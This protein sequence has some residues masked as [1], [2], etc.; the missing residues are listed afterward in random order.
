MSRGNFFSVNIIYQNTRGINSKLSLIKCFPDMSLYD[1]ICITE[2]WLKPDTPSN[3]IFDSE[4]FKVFRHDRLG[5]KGG[6][7]LVAVNFS[8]KISVIDMSPYDL[9]NYNI[10]IIALNIS[11]YTITF[12][13]LLIYIPPNTPADSYR[14]FFSTLMN[15]QALYDNP[16]IVIG[17]FNSP[18]FVENN[19]NLDFRTRIIK[20]FALAF[21]LMQF[22]NVKD[23]NGKCLDLA[24]ANFECSLERAP[25][26]LVPEDSYHPTL[27]IS[28]FLQMSHKFQP[29]NFITNTIEQN[30]QFNF[31]KA[32]LSDLYVYLSLIDWTILYNCT[33]VN[34]AYDIFITILLECFKLFVPVYSFSQNKIRKYPPWF[35]KSVIREI[36]KKNYLLKKKRRYKVNIYDSE[37]KLMS[38]FIHRSIKSEHDN[39]IANVERNI[40][41]NPKFFWS[42]VNRSRRD[43]SFPDVMHY[44]NAVL[45]EPQAIV[46]AFSAFFAKHCT[47]TSNISNFNALTSSIDMG[48][49]LFT[50]SHDIVFRA[51]R[52]LKPSFTAGLDGVPGF[53]VKDCASIL[54]SPLTFMF[55]LALLS[56]HFPAPWKSARVVPVYKSGDRSQVVNYRPISLVSNFAKVFEFSVVNFLQTAMRPV[57]SVDQHGGMPNRSTVTNLAC[58]LHFLNDCIQRG[59]QVDTIYMDLSKAFDSIDHDILAEK[60]DTLR[61]PFNFKITLLDY[62]NGRSHRVSIGNYRSKIFIPDRGVPQGSSFG[63]P[64]FG[65]YINDITNVVKSHILIYADD[66]KIYRSIL[67]S[68]DNLQLQSD[69]DCV[70]DWCLANKLSINFKKSNVISFYRGKAPVLYD[71]RLADVSLERV[72]STCD[73]GV[74]F[75]ANLTFNEHISNTVSAAARALGYLI[76][77]SGHWTEPNTYCLLFNT[78]IRSRTEYARII[79]NPY[80]DKYNTEIESIQKRF[81]KYMAFKKD[82]IYPNR[83]C[84]YLLLCQRFGF[85]TLAERHL[86]TAATFL[87][88]IITSQVDCPYLLSEIFFRVPRLSSR[89]VEP[90]YQLNKQN[91]VS[92]TSPIVF[93]CYHV[94]RMFDNMRPDLDLFFSNQSVFLKCL[95]QYT[96]N[97]R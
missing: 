41:S 65:I 7:V 9:Y 48:D 35:S 19:V 68:E 30:I 93:A 40:R 12:T 77:S 80:Y 50:L 37:I 22:N 32:L 6:G 76:R 23:G 57:I 85:M 56:G 44:E 42:F 72:F 97:L 75:S 53:F 79:W 51:A 84:D 16:L 58:F 25:Y 92:L 66:V 49:N 94:N 62:L 63:S 21:D 78:F 47:S 81:L 45:D 90:F 31:R 17:D 1:V 69:L 83:G 13:L 28:T 87:F 74:T 43:S 29:F 59:Q 95:V 11:K 55:N 60:L 5:K 36:N 27:S 15:V 2:S 54:A 14:D 18:K 61:L 96:D 10:N 70:R 46:D 88:K 52:S 8:Y 82:G 71:Y 26:P 67:S 91:I 4:I 3:E 89:N 20:N 38:S 86:I 33:N 39:Y 73:L 24:F 64:L 34:E